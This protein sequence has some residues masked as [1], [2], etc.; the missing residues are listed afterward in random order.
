MNRKLGDGHL[1][2]GVLLDAAE[3][4][5]VVA[6]ASAHLDRCGDCRVRFREIETL[7][8]DLKQPLVPQP[9][10]ALRQSVIGAFPGRP[11]L[12]ER[13]TEALATLMRA[14]PGAQLALLTGV[15]GTAASARMA[16]VWGETE[17]ELE[18]S[19]TISG[20]RLTAQVFPPAGVE[21]PLVAFVERGTSLLAETAISEHG[22]LSLEDLP[23]PPFDL[24]LDGGA[25]RLRLSIQPSETLTSGDTPVDGA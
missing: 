21:P 18:L 13:V 16:Y 5:R 25:R 20:L 19:G 22:L 10:A 8:V 23:P 12:Y 11:P 2:Q 3:R 15:S 7:L 9:P 6:G 1:E 14:A 17:V 4:G 24:V